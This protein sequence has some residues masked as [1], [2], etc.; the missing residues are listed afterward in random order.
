[1]T[2]R[3]ARHRWRVLR[4]GTAAIGLSLALV[5][6]M[7]A[8]GPSVA[9]S[10]KSEKTT[11]TTK[12]KKTAAQ[13]STPVP[14]KKSFAN[15][16]GYAVESATPFTEVA[17]SWVQPATSCS[18]K[19]RKA[20]AAFWVGFDGIKVRKVEQIG[21]KVACVNG[22]PRYT[23]WFQMFPSP[24]VTLP[25]RYYPVLPGS[26]F[27][28]SVSH[29]G[30]TYSLVLHSSTGWTYT[31]SKTA[32]APTT[33]AEWIAS[34]PRLCKLCIFGPL[35]DF[36]TTSFTGAEA[37]TGGVMEPISS[38]RSRG[39]PSQITMKRDRVIRAVPTALSK[40]GQSFNVIW[41][42]T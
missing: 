22:A 13:N 1:M 2:M 42:H 30:S 7:A 37:A 38:F 28:A 36:S 12:P 6:L 4:L 29:S 11:A 5:A 27:T 18:S 31:T 20:V 14:A 23:A 17:G 41:V 25:H 15:W 8:L 32:N 26:S 3:S 21:T 33:T 34:T 10:G 39:S 24:F 16:S 35:A 19:G 9:S 40:D